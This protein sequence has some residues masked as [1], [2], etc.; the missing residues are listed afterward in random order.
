MLSKKVRLIGQALVNCLRDSFRDPN[1]YRPDFDKLSV[2]LNVHKSTLYRYF[3]D[4]SDLRS[5]F[6]FREQVFV[7]DVDQLSFFVTVLLSNGHNVLRVDV[8]GRDK[9][10][11]T[12]LLNHR[13]VVD[14]KPI[15]SKV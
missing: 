14:T 10:Q 2:K 12:A 7:I 9:F 15:I 8:L 13:G 11:V 5:G 6:I 1:N 3:K 4:F